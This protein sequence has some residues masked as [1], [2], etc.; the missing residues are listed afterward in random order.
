MSDNFNNILD[1]CINRIAAGDSV[2]DCL[3]RYPDLAAELEPEL[4]TILRLRDV[5]ATVPSQAAKNLGRMRLQQEL[6]A[7]QDRELA[8]SRQSWL[9]GF[10]GSRPRWATA[11]LALVLT[12]AVGTSGAL[13][14]SSDANPG[15][16]FYPVKRTK[17]QVQLAFEFSPKDKAQLHLVLADR[18]AQEMERVAEKGN[19]AHLE[20]LQRDMQRN[21]EAV[22]A[23]VSA[24]EDLDSVA[25]LN[26]RL[27]SNASAT[28]ADLQIALSR[29]PESVQKEVA[30]VL[31]ASGIAF[32][33]AVEAVGARAPAPSQSSEPGLLEIRVSIPPPSGVEHAYVEMAGIQAFRVHQRGGQWI[34]ISTETHIFDLVDVAEVQRILAEQKVPPGPYSQVRFRVTGATVIAN[35]MEHEIQAP[36]GQIT[37]RRPFKV[38][39]GKTTTILLDFD[40]AR[41]LQQ[42]AQDQFVLD[43]QVGVQ[44]LEPEH[45]NR[46]LAQE[47]R[48]LEQKARNEGQSAAAERPLPKIAVEGVVEKMEGDKIFIGGK[49][50][51]LP[52]GVASSGEV[53]PG[54]DIRIEAEIQRD[55]SL[56]ISR[57]APAPPP[58]QPVPTSR[59]QGRPSTPGAGS[60][61]GDQPREGNAPSSR[62]DQPGANVV[63]FSGTVRSMDA[64]VWVIGNR[65]VRITDLSSIEGE[66]VVGSSVSVEGVIRSGRIIASRIVK[67]ETASDPKEPNPST[68]EP[69][70][71]APE[72]EAPPHTME[73]T[74]HQEAASTQ[75]NER[76]RAGDKGASAAGEKKQ[77]KQA[78]TRFQGRGPDTP[79]SPEPIAA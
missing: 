28:L 25:D 74:N 27:E 19:V 29:A 15:D 62:P 58:R 60:R 53:S 44:A 57:V 8:K 40:G 30:S 55:G 31:A 36:S 9:R 70:S 13:A 77:S 20:P 67:Q 66:P 71:L 6:R 14:A 22:T 46:L 61:P 65:E 54:Q 50:I 64:Q 21:L 37:L 32:S 11:A 73:R 48:K 3:S 49:P 69:Q 16:V 18:R 17:E 51:Q 10:L 43:P 72:P 59:P 78:Q 41:T 1:E 2:E 76:H 68:P 63:R 24:L 39:P 56:E 4:R 34:D 26:A 75:S 35:G 33:E 52:P 79:T 47:I 38:E 12:M 5:S 23:I 42:T 7:Q 45:Q